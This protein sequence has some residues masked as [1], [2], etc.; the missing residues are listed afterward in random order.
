MGWRVLLPGAG[1]A[2]AAV[3]TLAVVSAID[4][5]R[6]AAQPPFVTQVR[7]GLRAVGADFAWR[8]WLASTR[9]GH[10]WAPIWQSVHV[11]DAASGLAAATHSRA[12]KAR[13]R[14]IANAAEGYWDGGLARGLG[15]Y[16]THYAVSGERGENWFDDNGWLG[17]AFLST[18][19]VTGRRRYLRDAERALAYILG[20]GWDSRQG[21][22]WW[23]TAHGFKAGESVVTAAVLAANLHDDTGDRA[24][25]RDA[26]RLVDWANAH[27]FDARSGLYLNR[28]GG[29]PISYLQSP[30]I[31]AIAR[32]CRSDGFYCSRL[33]P[34]V[35]ATMRRFSVLRHAPQYD[36]M[37]VRFLV[38]SLKI[39]RDVRLAGVARTNADRVLRHAST[40]D[41]LFSRDWDGGSRGVRAGS[42]QSHAA[43]LEALAW[44]A[45][46]VG[47][48]IG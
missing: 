39:V 46:A 24:Y 10:A 5:E 30:M 2:A 23:S 42:L 40:R 19:E 45:V 11:L 31:D 25:F 1:A 8:G 20:A 9:K 47:M 17:L 41:G 22:I 34:L 44:A 15:G 13:L 32:L 29:V 14:T 38:D 27:L 43:S 33:H 26:R 12:D 4:S 6:A 7:Q 18:Y 36:A 3:A 35:D 16:S 28:V 21:G 37:F 48:K